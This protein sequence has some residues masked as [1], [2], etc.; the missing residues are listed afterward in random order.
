MHKFEITGV[1]KSAGSCPS[2]IEQEENVLQIHW[3]PQ[4]AG[5]QAGNFERINPPEAYV[6]TPIRAVTRG[7]STENLVYLNVWSTF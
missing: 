6:T 7:R 4:R 5:G 1:P 2:K 3:E